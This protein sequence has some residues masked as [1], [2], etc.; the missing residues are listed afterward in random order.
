MTPI[1][2]LDNR[3][4]GEGKRGPITTQIQARFFDLVNGR[5]ARVRRL[6]GQGLRESQGENMSEQKQ[7]TVSHRPRPA[8]A[9]SAARRAA[10]GPPPARSTST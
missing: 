8:A 6:A 7:L 9:L 4:I 1:R 5:P 10:V 3:V 2:E